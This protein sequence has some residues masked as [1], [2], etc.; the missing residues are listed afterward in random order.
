MM[1][2]SRGDS[3]ARVRP[4]VE[5]FTHDGMVLAII[6]R[7]EYSSKGIDFFTPSSF[8]Q[9]LGYMNRPLGHV[10]PAHVHNPVPREVQ[11]T[12]EA[13]F[14]L[15]GRVRV[16]LYTEEQVYVESTIVQTGDVVL[17]P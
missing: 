12:K 5:E 17:P 15:Q 2:S 11:Y 13:L 14:I 1:N 8:S 6:L 7:A 16:D 10:I 9:Q 3:G 4:F